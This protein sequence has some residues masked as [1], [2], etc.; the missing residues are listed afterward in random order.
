MQ[1]NSQDT[2]CSCRSWRTSS[3]RSRCAAS[4]SFLFMLGFFCW[5]VPL[6]ISVLLFCHSN[7]WHDT[8]TS[9]IRLCIYKPTA[10]SVHLDVV[11]RG[12]ASPADNDAHA[13]LW[14]HTTYTGGI[15]QKR[16]WYS[17]YKYEFLSRFRPMPGII[18]ELLGVCCP[19]N[20]LTSDIPGAIAKSMLVTKNNNKRGEQHDSPHDIQ[21]TTHDT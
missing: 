1:Y 2:R 13:T 7:D 8:G 6:R 17:G 15:A 5:L 4:K 11:Q 20:V 14:R 21:Q 12:R 10:C 18:E 19:A 16:T 9:D 3:L